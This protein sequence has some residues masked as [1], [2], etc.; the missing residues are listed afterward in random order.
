MLD[1]KQHRVAFSDGCRPIQLGA[2]EG[3]GEVFADHFCVLIR[4]ST[5]ASW[6]STAPTAYWEAS[7]FKIKGFRRS[8]CAST[9]ADISAFLSFSK[10]SWH[11]SDQ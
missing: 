8:G 9:G 2:L 1:S 10:A 6:D 5:L 3:S 7:V 11:F 4:E